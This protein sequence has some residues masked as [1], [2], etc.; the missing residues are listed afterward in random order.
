MAYGRY[1]KRRGTTSSRKLF[2]ARSRAARSAAVKAARTGNKAVARKL[3]KPTRLDT[4]KTGRNA[5]AI[6]TLARQVKSLQRENLGSF[7]KNTEVFRLPDTY[8]WTHDNSMCFAINNFLRQDP[9]PGVQASGSPVYIG[10]LSQT[11]PTVPTAVIAGNF[12]NFYPHW[13][14]GAHESFNFWFSEQKQ[15]AAKAGYRPISTQ[16]TLQTKQID[17]AY[18]DVVWYRFDLVRRKNTRAST[19]TTAHHL[20]LPGNVM[21]LA[22]LASDDMVARNRINRTHFEVIETKWIKAYNPVNDGHKKTITR[23]CK[24]N[25]RF[26]DMKHR[27]EED[28]MAG[29]QVQLPTAVHQEVETTF[30][31]QMPKDQVYWLVCNTSYHG[32]DDNHAKLEMHRYISWRDSHIIVSHDE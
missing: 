29:N 14:T 23:T 22:N 21:G 11:N 15:S 4:T 26:K 8:H 3:R 7:Q 12:N 13:G 17:M 25:F 31:S 9:G 5:N 1:S 2:G 24:I 16:I 19:N 10:D 30:L 20:N 32:G 6:V 27:P 18:G 28:L